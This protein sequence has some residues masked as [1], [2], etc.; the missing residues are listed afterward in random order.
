MIIDGY[1]AHLSFVFSVIWTYGFSI[2][3][4]QLEEI[5]KELGAPDLQLS[6]TKLVRM[7]SE[8]DGRT[9]YKVKL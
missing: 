7:P 2:E 9:L 4:K 8:T 3:D 1:P 6:K 5:F